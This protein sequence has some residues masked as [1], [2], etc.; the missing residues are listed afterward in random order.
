MFSTIEL[1]RS[2]PRRLGTVLRREQA[3]SCSNKFKFNNINYQHF[4]VALKENEKPD[5]RFSQYF[6]GYFDN[7]INI[8]SQLA[9]LNTER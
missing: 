7:K 1:E 4:F 5:K 3:C 9:L 6:I 2:E 8:A